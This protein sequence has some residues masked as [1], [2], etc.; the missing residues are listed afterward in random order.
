V[1]DHGHRKDFFQRGGAIMDFSKWLPKAFFQ[2]VPT[3]MKFHFTNPKLREKTCIYWNVN[4]KISTFKI[5]GGE[6]SPAPTFRRPC[7]WF[8]HCIASSARPNVFAKFNFIPWLLLA[9][10][11][12]LTHD[13]AHLLSIMRIRWVSCASVEH[14]ANT[15]KKC[16][17]WRRLMFQAKWRKCFSH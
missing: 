3:V 17:E 7:C 10:L 13:L 1:V 12:K 15:L 9:K 4:R 14:L 2:G 5:Q 6:A 16:V 8:S 11:R